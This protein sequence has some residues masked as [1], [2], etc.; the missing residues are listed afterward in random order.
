MAGPVKDAPIPNQVD[1][2]SI[3][4]RLKSDN[5]VS[6]FAKEGAKL[7]EETNRPNVITAEQF[8]PYVLLF[9]MDKEQ[10]EKDQTY[11][12]RIN[13]LYNSYIRD[14]GI[15]L[16]ELTVVV[17]SKENPVPLV[18]LNRRF[19][20]I[21]GDRVDGKSM[22]DTVPAAIMKTADTTRDQEIL[23]ASVMDLVAANNTPEQKEYFTKVRMDSAMVE[24]WFAAR[25]ASPTARAE[26]MGEGTTDAAV[27]GSDGSDEG[28]N[29][30]ISLDD[31]D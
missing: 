21:Q 20:R 25:N 5:I 10:Y 26:L 31:D 24:K 18:V 29:L 17:E 4:E 12:L 14:L 2:N 1:P 11:R 19:T 30:N 27:P 23:K 6:Q 13:R 8:M 3:A 22:R 16:Y 15:N 28:S 9:N 7:L